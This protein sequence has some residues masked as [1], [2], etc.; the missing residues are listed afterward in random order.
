MRRALA[1]L[2]L[3]LL[4]GACWTGPDFYA[5]VPSEQPIPEGKYKAVRAFALFPDDEAR[6][7]Q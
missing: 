6:F 4:L 5:G 1:T 7:G 3:P 2:I